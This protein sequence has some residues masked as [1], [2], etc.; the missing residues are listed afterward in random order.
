[1]YTTTGVPS[2]YDTLMPLD[3]LILVGFCTYPCSIICFGHVR[4]E[5]RYGIYLLMREITYT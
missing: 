1:M 3:R 2:C 5:V 4:V